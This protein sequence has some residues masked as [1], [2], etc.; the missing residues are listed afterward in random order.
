VQDSLARK[1][2]GVGTGGALDDKLR[3]GVCCDGLRSP[4]Q[5]ACRTVAARPGST[6]WL[7]D[8]GPHTMR[9]FTVPDPH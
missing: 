2:L 1:L 6:T 3:G 7:D 4:A 9:C 8:I 5:T